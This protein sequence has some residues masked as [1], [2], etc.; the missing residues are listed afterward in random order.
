MDCDQYITEVAKCLKKEES[1]A[2]YYLQL[3]SKPKIVG[4]MMDESIKR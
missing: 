3:Q 4:I 2:D 1:N